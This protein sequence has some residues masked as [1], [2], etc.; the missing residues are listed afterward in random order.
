MIKV[1]IDSSLVGYRPALDNVGDT[2]EKD[3]GPPE[4]LRKQASVPE[5]AAVDDSFM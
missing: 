2:T 3:P 5:G 1:L 4:S